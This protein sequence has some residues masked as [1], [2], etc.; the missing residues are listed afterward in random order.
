MRVMIY[1]KVKKNDMMT[2]NKE[3]K[4]IAKKLGYSLFSQRGKHYIWINGNGYKVS[5][6]KTPSDVNAIKSITR[7]FMKYEN[8]YA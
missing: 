5:T 1:Y 7:N 4:K 8:A 2:R 6:S 3:I